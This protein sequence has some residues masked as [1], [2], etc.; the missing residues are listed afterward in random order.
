MDTCREGGAAETSISNFTSS[1]NLLDLD[2][3]IKCKA[4]AAFRKSN[5]G[6][7]LAKKRDVQE[8]LC[9]AI[10]CELQ[11]VKIQDMLDAKHRPDET[12]NVAEKART[13]CW[14]LSLTKLLTAFKVNICRF[15]RR[16]KQ[17]NMMA[18]NEMVF[19]QEIDDLQRRLSITLIIRNYYQ[20]AFDRLFVLP[21]EDTENTESRSLYQS[22]YEFGW[23]LFL[24]IRNELPGFATSNLVN[25][26][27]VLICTL[28]LL[29]VNALEVGNPEVINMSFEGLPSTWGNDDFDDTLLLKYSAL[30]AICSLIP[31]LPMKGVH[32]MQKAFFHKALV[33]LFLDQSLL[34]N[35]TF[36]REIVKEG[37]LD[38]NLGTLN[39]NYTK[40]VSDISEID[41]R[42]LLSRKEAAPAINQPK[43]PS[44]YKHLHKLPNAMPSEIT[45]ALD[46]E[47]VDVI[48]SLD[49]R[50]CVMARVFAKSSRDF[51][52][53]EEADACFMMSCRL[54]YHFLQK[55]TSSELKLKPHLK[56][57]QLLKNRSLHSTLIACSLELAMHI[58]EVRV[59]E[60]KFPFILKCYA[61]DAYEFQKI[62]EVVV[63]HDTGLLGRDLTRH[64]NAVEIECL[65][66]LIFRNDSLLWKVL[67]TQRCLPTCNEVQ[68]NGKENAARSR[69][70]PRPGLSI[71]LRKFYSL[72]NLRLLN[73]CQSLALMKY[74]N[75]IWY[76]AEY[77]FIQHCGYLLKQRELDQLLICAI[78]LHGRVTRKPLSFHQ[79]LQHYR[80]QPHARSQVYRLVSLG[81]FRSG[82]I[83]EFYNKIYIKRMLK[84]AQDLRKATVTVPRSVL[85]EKPP[86]SNQ[87]SLNISVSAKNL[88]YPSGTSIKILKTKPDS[89]VEET[90]VEPDQLIITPLKRTN[91]AKELGPL[92]YPNIFKRQCIQSAI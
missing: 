67:S 21:E 79:I 23:V 51:L 30:K 16:M 20:R 91:S 44:R 11:R 88:R 24:T 70:E 73:L 4:L 60:L 19:Q 26:C 12:K 56:M 6:G 37:L 75:K 68:A 55:I 1:C 92:P 82:N 2:Q 25:G 87:I 52:S 53:T 64:L 29:Y 15:M 76:I 13:S 78:H 18:K 65:G 8:F 84:F 17:W 5:A 47:D 54:Y 40:H 22:L 85:H 69:A 50:L 57:V 71:C 14:N 74:F 31:E 83:I 81:N 61:L 32:V 42:V 66:S 72:A 34:G 43:T 41:E 27:Q 39:R 38:V 62:L 80:C 49:K 58:Q 28:N 36:K 63:R 10:Y 35:D 90:L 59:E 89:V 9:C 86:Q 48:S 3:E 77:S 45:E 7:G 33:V 46:A